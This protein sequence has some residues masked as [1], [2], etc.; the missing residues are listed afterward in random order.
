M[1]NA[2]TCYSCGLNNA[3]AAIPLKMLEANL[4]RRSNTGGPETQP[5]FQ[6]SVKTSMVNLNIE[7]RIRDIVHSGV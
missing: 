3:N 2:K 6:P 7:Q 1:R 4:I 5:I